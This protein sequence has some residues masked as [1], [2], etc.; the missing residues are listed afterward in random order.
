MTAPHRP[1]VVTRKDAGGRWH[2]QCLSCMDS[3][4]ASFH[5]PIVD[6]W[7]RTHLIEATNPT[8]EKP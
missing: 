5:R 6:D 3:S 4:P 8:Q 2:A 7:R 1:D